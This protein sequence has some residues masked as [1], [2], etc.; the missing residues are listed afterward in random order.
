VASPN[1]VESWKAT[2]MAFLSIPSRQFSAVA[3]GASVALCLAVGPAPQASANGGGVGDVRVVTSGLD[4]PRGLALTGQGDLYVAEAGHGGGLYV[5]EG[6]AGP[7]YAGLTGRL[8]S[9]SG[10]SRRTVVDG[11]IS[12][13]G[14]D[15]TAAVGFVAVSAQ[16]NSLFGQFSSGAWQVPEGAPSNDV[17]DA[18]RAWLGRTVA[19]RQGSFGALADTGDIDY[20]WTADHK[21]LQPDQFPESNPNGLTTIGRNQVVADAA[22]NLIATVSNR[23][24]VETLAYLQVPPGSPT[25]AVPTCVDQAPDG[26][27]YVGELLGGSFEPGHSRVWRI[28]HGHATVKWTGFTTIQGC[29]FDDQG[30]FYVTEF[31]TH[32][33][34]G[35]DPSGDVV[36]IAPNG[37]RTTF[38]TGALFFPSGFV[39]HGDSVYV[40][41]WSIM[42]A[43]NGGGPTGQVVAIRVR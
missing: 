32:G 16:G 42:P 6:P 41:N 43:D 18:A 35:P 38:G 39:A 29:G 12:L 24:Q 33:L 3:A 36:R 27:L 20:A 28:A 14:P 23:G 40:S 8:S 15:G 37:H 21:D 13:A 4:N 31:Q 26:S 11:L 34:F 10:G 22:G 25:D 19:L 7:T 1:E 9:L 30:D 17:V 2:V 5:G